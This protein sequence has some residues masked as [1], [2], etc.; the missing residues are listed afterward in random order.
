M[1]EMKKTL[2]PRERGRGGHEV[3]GR[4]VTVLEI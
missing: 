1:M 3:G 2:Y 4:E